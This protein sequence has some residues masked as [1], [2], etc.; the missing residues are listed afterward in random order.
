MFK[1]STNRVQD[2]VRVREGNR[3][4]DLSVDIDPRVFISELNKAQGQLAA[5]VD[6]TD[7]TAPH[8]VQA[9]QGFAAAIFGKEQAG[10]LLAFY[11]SHAAPVLIICTEYLRRRLTAKIK[12][13]QRA[14][15]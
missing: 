2:T 4:L 12:R 1:I 14:W 7:D 9:A 11:G 5:V 3:S 10:N 15:R 8:V 13:A 6:A